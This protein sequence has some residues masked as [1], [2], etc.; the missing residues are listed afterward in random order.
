M[1]LLPSFSPR[2]AP[3]SVD[4]TLALLP[5]NP[6][7]LASGEEVRRFQ[8]QV[9]VQLA[10]LR[11]VREREV[12]VLLLQVCQELVQQGLRV[13]GHKLLADDLVQLLQGDG[14]GML[15]PCQSVSHPAYDM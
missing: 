8:H 4:S 5:A 15:F 14:L 3:L 12:W 9:Q 6:Q 13:Q 7:L 10:S 2:P 1:K 11:N